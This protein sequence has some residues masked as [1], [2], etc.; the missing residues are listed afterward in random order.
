MSQA[1]KFAKNWASYLGLGILL[2]VGGCSGVTDI[3]GES[4]G[5]KMIEARDAEAASSLGSIMRSQQVYFLEEQQFTDNVQTLAVGIPPE[6]DNYIYAIDLQNPQ[7]AVMTATAKSPE[8]RSFTGAVYIIQ[9][10]Q[11]GNV[12]M[13]TEMCVGDAPGQT[14]PAPPELVPSGEQFAAVCAAGSQ[15]VN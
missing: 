13:Q 10:A 11:S 1:T 2:A 15:A 12:T 5:Q 3:G 8:Q 6:T 14:P 4:F 9:E 7:V